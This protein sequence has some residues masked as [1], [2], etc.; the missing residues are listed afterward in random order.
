MRFAFTPEQEVFRQEIRDFLRDSIP[1]E[2]D[3]ADDGE[4][5]E[6]RASKEFSQR[7][8][9]KGWIG[10]AWPKEHGGKGM[11]Y[12]ERFVYQEEMTFG[13]APMGHH[14]TAE[15]QMGPSIILDGNDYQKKTYLPAIA[16]GEL[17]IC[18]G[19][20][21]PNS[22]SDLASLST[23]AVAD[24]D[25]F[26]ITGHK[27]WISNAHVNDYIWLAARTNADAPKHKGISVFMVPVDAPGVTVKPIWTMAGSRL[28]EVFFDNVRVNRREM[29]GEQDRGWYVV[30]ANLDFER[31]GIERVALNLSLFEEIARFARVTQRGGKPLLADPIVAGKLAEIAILFQVGRRLAYRVSWL[32]SQGKTPN[33]EA[34]VSKVFGTEISQRV[35]KVGMELMGH[36]GQIG[37]GS[38]WAK[39]RGYVQRTYLL[40]V[41]DTIRGGTSE[42]QRNI[43]AQRGL[44]L[45]R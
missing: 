26:V 34:S 33:Y 28:N 25:D 21:E 23:R 18:I 10:L 29:V 39:L 37:E 9:A 44:G 16:R 36:Y 40:S 35:A 20:S 13:R 5:S 22:G 4:P 6:G 15:R 17:S 41:S 8:A 3:G 1:P 11:G 7:L 24:G 31:S 19:Y 27:I 2:D 12:I 43:V 45:P 14:Q 32:Q 30:A 42:V 38:P